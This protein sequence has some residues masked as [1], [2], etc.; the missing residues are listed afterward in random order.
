MY[1]FQ[2]TVLDYFALKGF[3][4]LLYAD[5]YSAWISIVKIR[6]G[7]ANFK[8]LTKFLVH[9][10][11]TFGV[12]EE[13]STNGGSPSKGHEYK[14]FSGAMEHS[15]SEFFRILPTVELEGRIRGESSKKNP[16]GKLRSKRRY[17]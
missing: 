12:P 8:F 14:R 13:I 2:M 4:Y 15:T 16:L 1:P 7:E 10:F 11:A 9:L 5:R 3:K 6:I 17:R